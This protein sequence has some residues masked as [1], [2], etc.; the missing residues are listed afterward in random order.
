MGRRKT[1]Q[2][3]P[4]AKTFRNL[5]TFRLHMLAQRSERYSDRYFRERFDLNL[6]ECRIIGITGG[7]ST[8]TFKKACQDANLE[9][10]YASRI[11]NRLVARGLIQKI[12]NPDDQR[13]VILGLTEA[14]RKL[15]SDMHSAAAELNRRFGSALDAEQMR[16]FMACLLLLTD[17]VGEMEEESAPSPAPPVP[18]SPETAL[19]LDLGGATLDAG[20]ARQLHD[21]LGQ[22]LK[23]SD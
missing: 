10:S 8:V 16:V 12:D 9:K 4:P 23:R 14:G 13:S 18:V 7:Y 15:H 19:G 17:R 20:V 1:E 22:I 3:P 11:V 6:P 5:L 2:A 21:L